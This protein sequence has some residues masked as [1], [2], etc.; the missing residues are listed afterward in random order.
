MQRLS[1]DEA[2]RWLRDMP[3]IELMHR[4]HERRMALHPAQ[5]VTFVLDTNPNYTNVC[6]TNCTFCSFFRSPGHPDAYVLTAEEVVRKV[7]TAANQ[8]ATTVLLQ[9]GHN[10]QL[11]LDYYLGIID[12]I[13]TGVP[14]I[15]LHLFSPSEIAQIAEA[16]DMSTEGVLRLF[17]DRGIRSMPGGGAEILVDRVR[18]RISPKKLSASGWLEIMRQAHHVGMKTSATMMY[19]HLENEEDIVTHLCRIRELQ[20]ETGGFYAFIPWSFKPGA[21]PLSKLV[22]AEATP[23][24]YLRI[25]AISRLVLDNVSHI[26]ASWFGEGWRAGQLGLFAGADDFGGILIEENVL[27]EANHRRAIPY[28]AMLRTIREAGFAPVQR[29]T[30]YEEVQRMGDD[31]GDPGGPSTLQR[32]PGPMHTRPLEF[33]EDPR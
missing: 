13:A 6:T 22:S 24:Y 18:R 1:S 21:S 20:D 9:G 28:E 15:H 23:S 31:P 29:T 30:L 11:G 32:V 14:R 12:A 3:L 25:L 2:T 16:T 10:P 26:Q 5:D 19:G 4:A 33:E 7:A 27:F 17:W 8:G